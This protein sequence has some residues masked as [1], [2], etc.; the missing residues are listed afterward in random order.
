MKSPLS[1][2]TGTVDILLVDLPQEAFDFEIGKVCIHYKIHCDLPGGIDERNIELPEGKWEL[3]GWSD[4]LTE[5]QAKGLVKRSGFSIDKMKYWN[6]MCGEFT[7]LGDA[8]PSWHSFLSAN[9]ITERVYILRLI[10]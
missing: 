7:Y 1:L 2:N 6:Y 5:E 10:K 8:L 9:N 4:E 3:V